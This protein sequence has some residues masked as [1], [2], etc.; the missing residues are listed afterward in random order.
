[1]DPY[2]KD[3]Y[4]TSFS[5]GRADSLNQMEIF[6]KGYG[7]MEI[8]TEMDYFIT[9]KMILFMMVIGKM[10]NSMAKVLRH[11]KQVSFILEILIMEKKLERE[12]LQLK[13][14]FTKEI[15]LMENFKDKENIIS[16]MLANI[17]MV[18]LATI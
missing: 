8:L 2:I 4:Q 14:I 1:M 9:R 17:I 11:G 10:I 12:S 3:K 13:E 16:Q 5:M 18:T 6:T 7:K 15:L